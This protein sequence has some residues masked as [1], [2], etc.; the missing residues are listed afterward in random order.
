[1]K[2]KEEEWTRLT[3]KIAF[4]SFS[5]PCFSKDL[6]IIDFQLIH[7]RFNVS[8]ISSF[9]SRWYQECI[10]NVSTTIATLLSLIPTTHHDLNHSFH[11]S[12]LSFILNSENMF[13]TMEKIEKSLKYSRTK[14]TIFFSWKLGHIS[15]GRKTT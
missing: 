6:I 10:K 2:E 9:L 5:F 11:H 4:Q 7:L 14:K 3:L 15:R 8:W 1:M 12:F 13:Q